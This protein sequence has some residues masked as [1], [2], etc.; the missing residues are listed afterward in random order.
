[1][2]S[3]KPI[4]FC[5]FRQNVYKNEFKKELEKGISLAG[6]IKGGLHT[7]VETTLK[8]LGYEL[9]ELEFG[10]RGLLRIFIDFADWKTRKGTDSEFIRVEDCEK[11]TR[12]LNHVLTVEEIDYAR[13]EVSSPGIDRPLNNPSDY[14]RFAGELVS[15]KLKKA[16]EN[17]KNFEGILGVE[18]DNKYS[19][20]YDAV[21][22]DASQKKLTKLEKAQGKTA[23]VVKTNTKKSAEPAPQLKLTF[24]LEEAD[25]V[26]LVPQ[27]SFK[28]AAE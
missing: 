13:L 21:V 26:R 5:I 22:K 23:V 20:V 25:R 15:V 1:M 17:R 2:G 11:A 27:I 19:I 9:V 12:Q 28:Q 14:D 24:T 16:F 10:G 4:F 8:G 7:V 6:E 18:E 3:L